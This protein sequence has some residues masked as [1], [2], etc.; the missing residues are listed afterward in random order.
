[1]FSQKY[2]L[3]TSWVTI[4]VPVNG[5][6][7]GYSTKYFGG[8]D[9]SYLPIQFSHIYETPYNNLNSGCVEEI[10]CFHPIKHFECSI[11]YNNFD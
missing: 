5:D 6:T 7:L 3:R 1:M 10:K 9:I 8:E 4:W 11:T 2:N